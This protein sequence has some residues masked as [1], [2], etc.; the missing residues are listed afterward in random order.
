MSLNKEFIIILRLNY[1][2]YHSWLTM[3]V[4]FV[5]EALINILYYHEYRYHGHSFL[6]S[7]SYQ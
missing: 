7:A 3:I 2:N 4:I 1:K 5:L 6:I